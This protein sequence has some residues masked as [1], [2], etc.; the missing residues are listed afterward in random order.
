MKSARVVAIIQAR[1]GST[2]LPGK[3]LMDLSGKPALIRCVR[4]TRRAKMIDDVGVATTIKPADDAI[5][6]LCNQQGIPCFRGSEEDVLDRYFRAATVFDAD[7]IVRITGDCPLIEPAIIDQTIADF[8]TH[9]PEVDYACNFLPTRTFPRGLDTE[10]VFFEALERVW[11]EDNNPA[12]REHVTPYIRENSNLFRISGVG[13]TT[14]YSNQRWTLDTEEDLQFV[15]C[16][17]NY[18]GHDRFTWKEVLDALND[19]PDWLKINQHIKQ[20]DI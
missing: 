11:R 2:R 20:K 13:N 6:N 12:R 9:A 7:I 5:A 19:H 15:R 17:Y 1:M 16:I 18:F 14:D 3:V 10:V 4:R 8:V